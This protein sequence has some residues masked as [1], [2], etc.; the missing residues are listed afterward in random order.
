MDNSAEYLLRA[1]TSEGLQRKLDVVRRKRDK[2]IAEARE[3]TRR[4]KD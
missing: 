1:R 2:V 4:A 3:K